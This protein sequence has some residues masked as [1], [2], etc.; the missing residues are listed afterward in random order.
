M[1]EHTRLTLLGG[2][3]TSG[4]IGG[5]LM[6]PG[7]GNERGFEGASNLRY[8]DKGKGRSQAE[9]WRMRTDADC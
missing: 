1:Y 9:C 4:Y 8:E 7:K 3:T 5:G 2:A 6:T